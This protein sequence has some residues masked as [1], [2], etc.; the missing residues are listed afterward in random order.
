[1]ISERASTAPSDAAP[2]DPGCAG[3]AGARTFLVSRKLV[4]KVP[5][6]TIN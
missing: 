6:A 3:K 4:G 2:N 1:M 5:D